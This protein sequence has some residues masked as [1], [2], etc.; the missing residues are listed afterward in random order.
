MR[1]PVRLPLT[2]VT[3]PRHPPDSPAGT[4][5]ALLC[6]KDGVTNVTRMFAEA[7]RVLTPGGTFLLVSLGDPTRRLC[8]LCCE[9]FDWTVQVLLLPKISVENQATVDGRC[10][11]VIW[12]G[13][14]VGGPGVM[15]Q[16]GPGRLLARFVPS[17]S[18]Y[19]HS[20]T[21]THTR[22]QAHQ[23]HPAAG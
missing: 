11:A 17:P 9:R 15:C 16:A 6:S 14:G 20:N 18:S 4:V 8:L 1:A 13:W 3:H 21:P 12:D 10:G 2:P 19:M 22:A 23:R 7:S 5:D